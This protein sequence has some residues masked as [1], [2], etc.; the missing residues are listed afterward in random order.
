MTDNEKGIGGKVIVRVD[1]DLEDLIPGFLENRQ[2]DIRYIR[3][4]LGK[5]D[6]DT[7]GRL[8]H[9]M[10]GC[11]GGYGFDMITDIG[12]SIETAAKGQDS[13]QIQ[14]W[15]AELEYLLGNVEVVF[16]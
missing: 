3:E 1:E 11:G 12:A 13:D 15:L 4:S 8:G 2:E 14:K 7:I 6:Y 10:K 9:S 5:G 16:E